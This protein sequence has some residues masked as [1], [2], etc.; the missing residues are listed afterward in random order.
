MK[1]STWIILLIVYMAVVAVADRY[2]E[3]GGA[4]DNPANQQ[5]HKQLL[6]GRE[7]AGRHGLLLAE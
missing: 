6:W 3:R 1:N 7:S 4:N 5:L 2:L